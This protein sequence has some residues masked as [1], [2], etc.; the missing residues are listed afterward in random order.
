MI[1]RPKNIVHTCGVYIF[2]NNHDEIIYIGKAKNLAM[3]IASYFTQSSDTKTELLLQEAQTVH[4]IPTQTELEALYLETQLIKMYQP[5]FNILLK[6]GNPF[7]YLF[8][9]QEKLPTMQLVKT[10][11]KKGA[12]FGPFL[13]KKAIRSVYHFLMTTFQLKLCKT[14]IEQGCLAYHIGLCAGNCKKDF[15]INFYIFKITLAQQA[16]QYDAQ[17][18]ISMIDQNVQ[19]LS[20]KLLFEQAQQLAAYKQSLNSIL[21]TVKK[22]SSAM[23]SK[24]Q[25][26][27]SEKNLS[28]LMSIQQRLFLQHVPY[29]ID[30]FDISHLQGQAIVG[31]CVRYVHG[32]P[33]KKSFRHFLIK[34]LQ[35]QNDYAALQEIVQRRYKNRLDF[36]N[37]IIVDGGKGQITAIKPY[38]KN[39]ELVGLAKS[40][41]TVIS[42]DFKHFIKLNP[43]N[44]ADALLLQIRDYTHHFAISYHRKKLSKN[45]L[46]SRSRQA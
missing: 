42:S 23:P 30:C 7:L 28:I 22:L 10:K 15:D 37:L 11:K 20:K 21:E 16:L 24:Q 4:T 12:Y 17:K 5:K 13:S 45:L 46:S 44:E 9:S 6:E 3:R 33:E 18:M 26:Q 25:K 40:E 1:K 32:V 8:F 35:N 34:T 31:A 29:V 39:T 19:E 36:P 14:K 27:S 43:Q 38:I 41:E 2:K